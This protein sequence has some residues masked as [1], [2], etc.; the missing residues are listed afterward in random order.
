MTIETHPLIELRNREGLT[1]QELASKAKVS[2]RQLARIETEHVQARD[3]TLERLAKALGVDVGV[4]AGEKPLPAAENKELALEIDPHNLKTLRK[5]KG[6]SRSALATKAQ[7]SERQLARLESSGSMRK[8]RATTFRRIA[9]AL[10][11]NVEELSGAVPV[12]PKLAPQENMETSG[13]R[14]SPQLL[15]A[16]DLI[17]Y[18]YGPTLKQ[19]FE[20]APLLF[21]LLAEGSLAW[22]KERLAEIDEI[23]QRLYEMSSDS[24]LYFAGSVYHIDDG[25]DYERGSIM[26]TDILGDDIRREKQDLDTSDVDPFATY[27]CKM[28]KDLGIDGIVNFEEPDSAVYTTWGGKPYEVC[29]DT[30]GELTGGSIY[31][32][33]ALLYGDVRLS[34]IPKDLLKPEAKDDRIA[35]L[36]NKLSDDMRNTIDDMRQNAPDF[37]ELLKWAKANII[38]DAS[39]SEPIKGQSDTD[40]GHPVGE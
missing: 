35:W 28:A 40:A 6:L 25:A 18:R 15:L 36:E 39:Q 1:R 4:I 32:R 20:L 11:A 22:R 27:L 14:V 34:K 9:K 13:V 2:E 30:L 10:G 19:V 26:N 7:V 24:Q 3:T 33:W 12:A 5:G 8:T 17:Q 23:I 31:A 16:Y 38:D 29:G 21:V 37:E